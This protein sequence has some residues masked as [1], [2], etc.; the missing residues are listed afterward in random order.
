MMRKAEIDQAIRELCAQRG[1]K[2]K[3]WEVHPADADDGPS[4]WSG[5]SAGAVSW[6]KAVKLRRRLIAELEGR[7]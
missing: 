1:W 6:P 5:N 2:F 3:P 7:C 4:P